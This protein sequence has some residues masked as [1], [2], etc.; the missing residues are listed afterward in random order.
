MAQELVEWSDVAPQE[1]T[2]E[3]MYSLK[4]TF[5]HASAR[6]QA[7]TQEQGIPTALLMAT[8]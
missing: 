2:W 7:V 6:R 4:E 5:P 3:D 1:S 8:R